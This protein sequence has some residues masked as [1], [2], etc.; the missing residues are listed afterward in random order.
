VPIV[1]G[2]ASFE[3]LDEDPDDGRVVLLD[4]VIV[5]G[6]SI[7][8]AIYGIIPTGFMDS[9]DWCDTHNRF[10]EL[11][12]ADNWSEAEN[13]LTEL[14]SAASYPQELLEQVE[15]R[16]EHRVAGARQMTTK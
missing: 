6:K 9:L 1:I 15:Y 16:I 5:K 3:G 10:M 4:H 2:E 11:I 14:R 12:D 13:C 7:P 8:V